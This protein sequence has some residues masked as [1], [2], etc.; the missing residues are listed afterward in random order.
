MNKLVIMYYIS[1]LELRLLQLQEGGK[2]TPTAEHM[3]VV[4]TNGQNII[5]SKYKKTCRIETDN[6]HEH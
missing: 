3:D 1:F 2:C 5:R 6:S 4:T